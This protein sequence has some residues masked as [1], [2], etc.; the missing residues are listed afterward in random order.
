MKHRHHIVPRY[1]GGGDE[2]SNIIE[3]TV[4]EHAEAHKKLWEK[5]GNIEDYCAWKG[6]SE[7]I[8]REEIFRLLM[9]P[10]G[11]KHTEETKKKISESNKGK[12]KH[13]DES[14]EMISSSRKGKKLSQEHKDK[15]SAAM[16]NNKNMNG[17]KMS[18]ETKKKL[19]AKMKGNKNAKKV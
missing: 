10:T 6:L 5:H 14:K 13:T 15:I 7:Q 1:M 3:L 2:P 4:E 16:K 11:R 17:K 12:V 18:D 19:S 9:D 8:G